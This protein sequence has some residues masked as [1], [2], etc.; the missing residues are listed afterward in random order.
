MKLAGRLGQPATVSLLCILWYAAGAGAQTVSPVV[1]EYEGRA[2]G[3]I[4]LV[5]GTIHPMN[6]VLEPRSFGM[7]E[8]GRIELRPLDAGITLELS[9]MSFRIPPGQSRFV[10]YKASATVLPS[11]FTV[12]AYFRGP[13]HESGLDVQV[14]LPHTVLLYD[15]AASRAVEAELVD[16]RWD[17]GSRTVVAAVMN[18]GGRLSRVRSVELRNGDVRRTAA[19]FPLLPGHTRIVTTPWNGPGMPDIVVMRGDGFEMERRLRTST[20]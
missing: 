16:V 7:S 5:N 8:D 6:V 1:V 4:E 3:R 19:G 15:G 9:A 20:N 12:Y 13:R 10:F 11:W 2:E 14:E 18:P 17:E